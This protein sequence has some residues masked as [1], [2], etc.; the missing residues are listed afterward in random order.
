[1]TEPAYTPFEPMHE[2]PLTKAQARAARRAERSAK[3]TKHTAKPLVPKT[4]NQADY[5]EVLKEGDSVFAIGPAGTG[6]TYLAARIAAQRML[7]GDIEKIIISRVTA[8][9]KGHQI[10]FLPGNI[11][12]KMAP[13]LTPVIEGIR[14]EVSKTQLEMWKSEGK[15]E[16]VPFEYMRGRTFDNACV[17]LDEAQN[18]EFDDLYL[19]LTRTGNGTQVVVAGDHSQVDI[20]NSGLEEIVNISDDWEIMDI[21]EFTEDDVVRSEMAKKWVKAISHRNRVRK[22]AQEAQAAGHGNLDSLPGFVHSAAR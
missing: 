3:Q 15:F 8:S 19:L 18:A 12:A 20:H 17:I 16:I 11:E 21:V 7:K 4:E 22:A 9:K 13:W 10:G 6:K 1:M 2:R 14:A 5:L